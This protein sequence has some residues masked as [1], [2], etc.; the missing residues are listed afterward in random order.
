[1][2]LG[3]FTHLDASFI[4]RWLELRLILRTQNR[5]KFIDKKGT[6]EMYIKRLLIG[7]IVEY[8][9]VIIQQRPVLGVM[10]QEIAVVTEIARILRGPLIIYSHLCS[11]VYI[12]N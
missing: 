8:R 12:T 11:S 5:F 6:A 1:M 10:E 2:L 7:M 3:S 4:T 9:E